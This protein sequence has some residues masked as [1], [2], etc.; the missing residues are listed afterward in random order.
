VLTAL[1]PVSLS[2]W[3][4]PTRFSMAPSVSEPE[5]PVACAAVNARL[6]VTALPAVP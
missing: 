3:P 2:L 4:E 5:P 6:T 1:L